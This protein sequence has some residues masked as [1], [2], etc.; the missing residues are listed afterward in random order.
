MDFRIGDN[1][2]APSISRFTIDMT[3]EF[4]A[5]TLCEE[6]LEH[7]L[8]SM[9]VRE[10]ETRIGDGWLHLI[11]SIANEVDGLLVVKPPSHLYH[12][13]VRREFQKQGIARSMLAQANQWTVLHF[14]KSIE[15]VN[16]SINS[17]DVYRR[18][19]F[20]ICDEVVSKNGV[21]YQPMNRTKPSS[22]R[23]EKE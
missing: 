21:L 7:L 15:T 20:S 16:S 10:T 2:D 14:S 9:H 4:I 23:Q 22:G 5:P 18:L 13:F 17:I 8:E 3:R 11:C 6:G 1:T 12:L 19:G